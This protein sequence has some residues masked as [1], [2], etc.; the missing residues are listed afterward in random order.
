M[1]SFN[2][3]SLPPLDYEPGV[4][5]TAAEVRTTLSTSASLSGNVA[6]VGPDGG[7]FTIV[8]GNKLASQAVPQIQT[9]V[10]PP[11]AADEIQRMTFTG[12]TITGGQFRLAIWWS[13][14]V[15]TPP[16]TIQYPAPFDAT[17]LAQNIEDALNASFGPGSFTVTPISTAA[18]QPQL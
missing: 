1:L 4:K 2:N 15:P 18:T 9:E 10:L 14:D 5:P 6:V 8:F 13:H 16:L 12:T 17:T 3:T 7:P 11:T